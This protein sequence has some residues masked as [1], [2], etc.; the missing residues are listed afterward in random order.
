MSSGTNSTR[1]TLSGTVARL[2]PLALPFVFL[3]LGGLG[4]TVAQSFGWLLPGEFPGGWLEGYREALR[5]HLL[6]SFGLS[7]SVALVSAGLSV[8]LGSV[9]AYVIWKLPEGLRRGA[10]VYKVGLIL[11][12]AAVAFVILI[13]WS[14]SGFLASLGHHLGLVETPGDFPTI[15]FGGNGLGMVLAY[16]YKETPFVILLALAVLLRTDPRLVQTARMF[17][18][19]EPVIFRR[20]ILPRLRPVLNT[21]FIILY[22]Y[23][24][25]AFDIPFLLGESSPGMLSIEIYNL[26]FN[27]DLVNRPTAMALLV[28]MLLFSVVFIVFY[29][30]VARRLEQGER[31]L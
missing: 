12:H 15:L 29:T 27:R 17:G 20:I 7:L 28:F 1:T 22:L 23:T 11:P 10:V 9:A 2:S 25:G 8:A 14:Q 6:A 30:R 18:A 5:P 24:F 19:S 21:A 4:L 13:L 31:K 16:T 3:F 26:Y